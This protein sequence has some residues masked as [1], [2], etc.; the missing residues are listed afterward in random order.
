M[1]RIISTGLTK[2]FQL[3]P[4]QTVTV[5]G[6]TSNSI[7]V[8]AGLDL[9]IRQ[10]EFITLVQEGSQ[11]FLPN[12]LGQSTLWITTPQGS[13]C[14]LRYSLPEKADPSVYFETAPARCHAP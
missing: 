11:V 7:Q 2:T 5:D 6:I 10:G 12:V 8:L 1:D 9:T 13:R 4:G 14:Q 3:K